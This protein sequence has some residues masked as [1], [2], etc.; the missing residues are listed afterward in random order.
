M[1]GLLSLSEWF[2]MFPKNMM[3]SSPSTKQS[4][5]NS[6][7]GIKGE[8]IYAVGVTSWW[9]ARKVG[10][11]IREMW[12]GPRSTD[13][14][15]KTGLARSMLEGSSLTGNKY[16]S[17]WVH[18]MQSLECYNDKKR[19]KER[20]YNIHTVSPTV[21]PSIAV[22]SAPSADMTYHKISLKL[23]VTPMW[24]AHI[25]TI[26]FSKMTVHHEISNTVLHSCLQ[27]QH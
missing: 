22:G 2:A 25:S 20:W 1:T 27:K 4:K 6:Q 18:N 12:Q 23:S 21:R 11:P 24:E 14:A 19:D 9:L 8:N 3:P 5:N 7:C 15:L 26:T 13:V 10:E 17:W 16:G